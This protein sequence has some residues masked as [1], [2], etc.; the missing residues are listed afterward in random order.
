VIGT[1]IASAVL[2]MALETPGVADVEAGGGK[3]QP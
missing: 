2:A 1:G 3:A